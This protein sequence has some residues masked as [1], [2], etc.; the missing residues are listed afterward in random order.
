M[1]R[2]AE[3]LAGGEFVVTAEIAPPKG[4]SLDQELALAASLPAEVTAVNVTDNQGANM[5]MAP[6][7]VAALLRQRGIEPI[8]QMTCRDRN[9]MALQS[10]L[11]AASALGIENLLLLSGDHPRFG[12]HPQARPV[13]DLDSVQLLRAAEA[14]MAG[15]DLA[16]RP[17]QTSPVFFPGAAVTP[18]AEPFEL[19]FQ[20]VQKKAASGAR[21]FQ[22]QAVFREESLR[23]FMAQARPLGVP[24]VLGVILLKNVRMARY[25]NEHI[26]GVRVPEDIMTRLSEAADPLEQGVIIAREMVA[27]ARSECQGVHLMTLGCE[28]RIPQILC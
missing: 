3:K 1:S 13:F 28:D 11:L 9:R 25:L 7:A 10:D 12:D 24:V 15:H 8:L 20:K 19:M 23:R 17:L 26:P 18:E 22:T 6:L 4:V 2:F 21:F 27:L 16:G 14:L 5:R